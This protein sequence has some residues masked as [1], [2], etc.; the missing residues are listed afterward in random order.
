MTMYVT[1]VVLENGEV[2][3]FEDIYGQ[4]AALEKEMAKPQRRLGLPAANP[5]NV[6]V[7]ESKAG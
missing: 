3:F 1:A 6:H 4:D 7:N 5:A 2:R